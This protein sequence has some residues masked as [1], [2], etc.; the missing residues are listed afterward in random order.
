MIKVGINGFGRIGRFVFRAAQN[1]SDIQIVGINDLCPVDYLAYMLKYTRA[2]T[3]DVEAIG[4]GIVQTEKE[5]E[6]L[7][8]NAQDMYLRL[9]CPPSCAVLAV[10]DRFALDIIEVIDMSNQRNRT[11]DG[12]HNCGNGN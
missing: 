12:K 5:V 4:N 10:A 11:E 6:H 1:R 9:V 7:D 8:S 2:A 3:E